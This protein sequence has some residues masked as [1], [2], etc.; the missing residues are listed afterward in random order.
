MTFEEWLKTDEGV[1][2]FGMNLSDDY[3]QFAW[4]GWQAS[5]AQQAHTIAELREQIQRLGEMA[6]ICT[7]N[8][9][10]KVCSTCNCKRKGK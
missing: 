1:V 3:K 10:K 6:N 2:K 4:E 8:E 5:Q 9:L 7:Y